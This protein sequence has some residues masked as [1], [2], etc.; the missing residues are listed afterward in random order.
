MYDPYTWDVVHIFD[1]GVC[2]EYKT[3]IN[4]ILNVFR[5][6]YSRFPRKGFVL[7]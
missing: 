3:F 2:Y 5:K 1:F 7:N 6:S 4:K